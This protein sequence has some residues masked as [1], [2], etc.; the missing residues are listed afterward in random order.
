M[1]QE[2]RSPHYKW[3]LV[4]MLWLITLF[5]YA[6]RQAVFSVFPL[7]EQE[8][9]L[10]PV[11]LGLVGASFAWVYGL[12]GLFAGSI[13]DRV[14]RKS[15]ILWGLQA[16]S[17]ICAATASARNF[18]HLLIFRAAEGLG[19]TFYFPASM[20]LISDY[21]AKDTR[22]RAMGLH[23]TAVYV[24][25]IGGG[26]FAGLIAQRHGWRWSFVVFGVLGMLL[27]L[28]LRRYLHEA[29]RGAM[30]GGKASQ[31]V[32]LRKVLASA[33]S[34]RSF[35][36]LLAGFVC[37][38][39][40]A[41]VMLS[42]MPKFLYDRFQLSLAMAGLTA[43]VFLQIAS[44]IGAAIGGWMADRLRQRM[45]GGRMIVQGFGVLAGAPFVLWCGQT[46]DIT[47]VIL[48][49]TGWGL[50]KGIYD[51]NIFASVYDVVQVEARGTSAGLMNTVG[52]LAGGGTAPVVIGLIAQSHGLGL[53]ISLAGIVYLLA[54]AC[55]LTAG[56]VY[57]TRDV[58]EARAR[59]SEANGGTI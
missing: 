56:T 32:P 41:A 16:W 26:Y 33:W 58:L 5:N 46:L 40:V 12:S 30:D 51:A 4:G 55:L 23:Q 54:A 25:T 6:D 18:T 42:W 21:H 8:M 36:L 48:A 37:S 15:A 10:T 20:S 31:A 59:T 1:K 19:E 52:W 7:L 28:V 27:G 9:G 17:F 38:N 2:A 39:F 11:Q 43:T 50:F 13:V 44:L 29:P 49:L 22:S 47:S 35:R 14:Q 53:A 34:I 45:A 24:G 3:S 57:A